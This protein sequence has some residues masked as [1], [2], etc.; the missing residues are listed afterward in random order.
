MI[1]K[2][3]KSFHWFNSFHIPTQA[4]IVQDHVREYSHATVKY[5]IE[6]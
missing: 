2:K 1:L 3:S 5:F 4:T 6:I